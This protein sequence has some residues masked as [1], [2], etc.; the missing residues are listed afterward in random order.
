MCSASLTIRLNHT[1]A[2]SA[3]LPRPTA[4]QSTHESREEVKS[5]GCRVLR[6]GLAESLPQRRRVQLIKNKQISEM[7]ETGAK[8]GREKEKEKQEEGEREGERTAQ[9]VAKNCQ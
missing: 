1:E 8:K 6:W 7:H 3:A 9:R 2:R 4:E 5:E